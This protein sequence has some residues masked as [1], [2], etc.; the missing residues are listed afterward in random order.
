MK[1]VC[2]DS[3]FFTNENA[4]NAFVNDWYDLSLLIGVPTYILSYIKKQR[5]T[6]QRMI[7][8]NKNGEKRIVYASNKTLRPVQSKLI[9][10]FKSLIEK[11]PNSQIIAYR[12]GINA[13]SIIR[14]MEGKKYLIKFDIKKYY[15]HIQKKHIKK[16][17]MAHGYSRRGAQL[18]AHY[19]LVTRKIP[20]TGYTLETLQQGSPV[21][22]DIS[23]L[24]GYYYIDKFI[25][26]WLTEYTKNNTNVECIFARYSDNIAITVDSKTEGA[27][28]L[29]DIQDFKEY[30]KR[31][32]KIGGFLTHKW[33]VIP[34]SH[35]KRN[36]KFLGVILNK[37]ARI[38]RSLFET[39]RATLFNA[40]RVGQDI[41]AANYWENRG[42]PL[43]NE[44]E[45][46]LSTDAIK[47]ALRKRFL[48]VATGQAAYLKSINEE[49]HLQLRKLLMGSNLLQ[50]WQHIVY[51]SYL[52]APKAG[53][54]SKWERS[55]TT[56]FS[57]IQGEWGDYVEVRR[58]H[59]H[60]MP[61]IKTFSNNAETEEDF[62]EN[63]KRAI[64]T[65]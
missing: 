20:N 17:L 9:P 26:R 47:M 59:N 6:M 58:L 25:I 41:T 22:C 50:E 63:L 65:R 14:E 8:E 21:S 36:Q 32:L 60:L 40:C 18:I 10:L 49:Q 2:F 39:W 5:A 30:I 45:R 52:Q 27:I 44:A 3:D 62:L 11:V 4:G 33:G 24:V 19:C 42:I 54:N 46:F 56:Q 61:V 53:P 38:D 43:C 37:K 13:A 28:R 31:E 64:E 12:K 34:N 57:F 29:E 1:K 48:M 51:D 15:D 35:P 23:N 7:I 55:P 16:V